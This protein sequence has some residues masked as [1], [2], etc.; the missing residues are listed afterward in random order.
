MGSTVSITN[1]I[2]T[3]QKAPLILLNY[4]IFTN[5]EKAARV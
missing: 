2:A 4:V 5:G 1:G 3:P